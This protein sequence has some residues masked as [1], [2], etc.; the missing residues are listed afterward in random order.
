LSP[1]SR[2]KTPNESN[3][4]G[5][6]PDYLRFLLAAIVESCEDAIVSKDLNGT[7]T[8]WN[9]AAAGMFGYTA[10]EMIGQSILKIIPEQLHAEETEILRKVR[11]GERID[12]Y[13]TTRKRRDGAAVEV[14]LT[15][16]PIKEG[17][18]RVIGSSKIARDISSRK[19]ME[20]SLIQS[21]KLAAT[22]RMAAS[23]AH[24][25]NNPL[26]AVMNLVYLARH[27]VANNSRAR[28]YLLT[29]EKELERVAHIARQTL[30]YYR[31][32]GEPVEVSLEQLFEELLVLYHSKLVANHIS[33]DCRF[34]HLGAITATRGELMQIF[35]N[36]ITNAID[37]MPQSG[38]LTIQT[39][40]LG[41]EGVEIVVRDKGSGITLEN[42]TRIFEPFFSTK[43]NLGTGIG[44]W[45]TRQ[46]VEKHRGTITIESSTVSPGNGTTVAVSLPFKR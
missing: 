34:G 35:S 3:E 24:E 2:P 27:S 31:D 26:E 28:S 33:V 19:R 21:E 16:S 9:D 20:Q 42:L 41:E 6:D 14:S 36:L 4:T 5:C 17:E 45:A 39:R 23:I 11:A 32:P 40:E 7:I 44:L 22:G 18:G 43:G 1:H 10:D 8:T 38:L 15:I 30:G 12:H 29:A 13:E 37:A 46:L 25:V